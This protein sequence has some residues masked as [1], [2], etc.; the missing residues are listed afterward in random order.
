M[1]EW[2]AWPIAILFA[3]AIEKPLNRLLSWLLVLMF[4]LVGCKPGVRYNPPDAPQVDRMICLKSNS[5]ECY[6]CYYTQNG[7]EVCRPQGR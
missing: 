1:S 7:D 2:V 3:L 6:D 5:L 4:F